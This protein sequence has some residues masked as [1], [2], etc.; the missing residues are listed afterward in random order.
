MSKKSTEVI[1]SHLSHEAT[2]LAILKTCNAC[3][4]FLWGLGD[5]DKTLLKGPFAVLR[6]I[7]VSSSNFLLNLVKF[8]DSEK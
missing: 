1:W 6:H 5:R 8:S 2:K 7:F 3:C 4:P